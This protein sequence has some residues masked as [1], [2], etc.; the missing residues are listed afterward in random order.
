[1][2]TKRWAIVTALLVLGMHGQCA[3]P[4]MQAVLEREKQ[5]ART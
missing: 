1:M 3:D 5:R 4:Q 2:N